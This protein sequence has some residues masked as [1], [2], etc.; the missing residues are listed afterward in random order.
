MAKSEVFEP[1]QKVPAKIWADMREVEAAALQQ[2][3]NVAS[4]PFVF[5]HVAAMPDVHLGKG[6]TVGSVIATE[7]AIIPAAVGVDIGCGM[8]A[9]QTPLSADKVQEKIQT[10]RHS[11][12]RSIPVGHQSHRSLTPVVEEWRGWQTAEAL[13]YADSALVKR[14][15]FQL[16]TL[17]GGNHFIEICL[18]QD[19]RVWVML[20]SGSRHIGK[21]TAERHI[22][23]AKSLVSRL[24]L[25]LPDPDLA[26]F[27]EGTPE[28]KAYIHDL[29]WCQNYARQNRLEMMN[30]VLKDLS[31]AVH[32][33]EPIPR[34]I[35]IN[36]HHNYTEKERH[37]GHEVWLT[38]KGAVR[39]QKGEWGIIPGS[40][41]TRSYIVRGL[42]NPESFQSCSH[43]AGR[44][45][46]RTEAKRRFTL[47]DLKHQT[48]GVESR[49]DI[50]VLD[51]IPGAYK[52]IDK[53]MAN[54]TD[55]VEIV[56][57]LK[58]IMCVKG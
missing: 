54:Q 57:T 36:C 22:Q 29:Q 12:E 16:G 20:H 43:G 15:Q 23:Q 58:Q 35:E 11:I 47:E 4:L 30:L 50:G 41:G 51:E 46:S 49:K 45:M 17:G 24:A 39:A 14:A 25:Q 3:K 32:N 8:M 42:G 10:I 13:T 6:A 9:V 40:M 18:D 27:T 52:D 26:H 5:K 55:L 48:Q 28:F 53:V 21:A 34:L 38:R 19:R 31:H 1:S 2:L 33:R 37:F 56:A 44:R 7:E